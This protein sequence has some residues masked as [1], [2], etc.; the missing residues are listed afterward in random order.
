M[1]KSYENEI[2]TAILSL[3]LTKV[4]NLIQQEDILTSEECLMQVLI[5]SIDQDKPD[6]RKKRHN[7]RVKIMNLLAKNGV[8]VICLNR[9]SSSISGLLDILRRSLWLQDPEEFS[10]TEELL[11][12]LCLHDREKSIPILKEEQEKQQKILQS[13]K[14]IHKYER[15][16]FDMYERVIKKLL[17]SS[18]QRPSRMSG[19]STSSSQQS[20]RP[21]DAFYAGGSIL[22]AVLVSA[23]VL[24]FVVQR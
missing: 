7:T 12:R 22:V 8:D 15:K 21:S 1:P 6:N 9:K 5:D 4:K 3:D 24:L 18:T 13:S 19:R 10:Y 17:S 16:L 20:V 11:Y 2:Q 14:N 23:T